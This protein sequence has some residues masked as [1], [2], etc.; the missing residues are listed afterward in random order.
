[1]ITLKSTFQPNALCPCWTIQSKFLGLINLKFP[2]TH[3]F[4]PS[5]YC[6]FFF[7]HRA[8]LINGSQIVFISIHDLL[9]RSH[10][11][12]M[13]I[14]PLR[15][16]ILQCS[17]LSIILTWSHSGRWFLFSFHIWSAIPDFLSFPWHKKKEGNMN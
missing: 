1:M 16:F 13:C 11:P 15:C 6:I 8:F 12:K 10:Y 5:S 4:Y 3:V 17:S 14:A 9:N 2:S 7:F